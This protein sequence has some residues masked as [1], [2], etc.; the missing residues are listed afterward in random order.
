MQICQPEKLALLCVFAWILRLKLQRC[1]VQRKARSF[2]RVIQNQN[3]KSWALYRCVDTIYIYI[4]IYVYTGSLT[5]AATCV[6]SIPDPTSIYIHLHPDFPRRNCT[7]FQQT[8]SDLLSRRWPYDHMT[9]WPYGHVLAPNCQRLG[10]F[11]RRRGPG[12]CD[13]YDFVL[14]FGFGIPYLSLFKHKIYLSDFWV[15]K[16]SAACL[17]FKWNPMPKCRE[18]NRSAKATLKRRARSISGIRTISRAD[19]KQS[20]QKGKPR[21]KNTK[22][23]NTTL[24]SGRQLNDLLHNLLASRNTF[25]I[26]NLVYA[27]Q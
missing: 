23:I 25:A 9:I 14:D 16:Y 21:V 27:F 19:N 13:Y 17:K 1:E 22:E 15:N 26:W 3:E 4:Y 11:G 10:F 7:I 20:A 5:K 2:R 18:I 6:P 8:S 12:A 24:R